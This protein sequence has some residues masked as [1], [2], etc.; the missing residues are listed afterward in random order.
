MTAIEWVLTIVCGLAVNEYCDCSPWL[1]RRLVR[2]SARRRYT[3]QARAQLRADELAALIDERPGKLFKLATAI[4]FAVAATVIQARRIAGGG[5]TALSQRLLRLRQARHDDGRGVVAGCLRPGESVRCLSRRH[6]IRLA[7]RWVCGIAAC[8]LL[9]G[10]GIGVA[11]G[12][13]AL[14]FATATILALVPAAASVI[15]H[16]PGWYSAWFV[17]TDQRLIV[18]TDAAG[19][20]FDSVSLSQ[21]GNL[22]YVQTPAGRLLNYGMFVLDPTSQGQPARHVKDLPCSTELYRRIVREMLDIQGRDVA[23]E[24]HLRW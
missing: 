13:S 11:L 19:R 2:W 12:G 21:A 1:A 4:G 15:W 9:V 23:S 22:R 8:T 20:M 24:A 10:A 7:N 14:V 3:D 16:L 6:W 17:L 18:V 5:E